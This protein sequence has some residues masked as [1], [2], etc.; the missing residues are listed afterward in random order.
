[1]GYE[2]LSETE[3]ERVN[4][5]WD[6]L[7]EGE[8]DRA[9]LE[10]DQLQSR[11][12]GHPDL[13]I[14]EAAVC[15]EEDEP[16]R[17]LETLHGAERSADPALFFHLRAAAHYQLA[18]L[19]S[20]RD[21]AERAMAVR[22]DQPDTHDLLA[23]IYAHLGNADLAAEHAE[24]ASEIDPESFPEPLE[25]SDEEFDALVEKSLIELPEKVREQLAEV[26]VLIEPL[27]RLEV[28]TAERPP[29][30]P[31]LLGLFV[32]RDLMSRSQ[33][34]VPGAP[35]TIHLFRRN[36]LRVCTDREELA[37]EVRITVQHEVGHLLGLDEDDLEQ[38]G[39]A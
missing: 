15:L 26:P 13:R 34:D 30:S 38:W 16:G 6:L 2:T 27:P 31:D 14:V 4:Q 24:A 8:V 33:T 1:M 37:R 32:G 28:L 18:A 17:A 12:H 36:L 7:D 23:R 21:D 29:L 5:I 10:I 20:A 11:R 25:L 3:W 22:P 35:G 39:L 19:E 9:R